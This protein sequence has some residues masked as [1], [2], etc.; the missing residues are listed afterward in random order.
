MS[1]SSL[2]FQEVR[3]S[4]NSE[5]GIKVVEYR[6]NKDEESRAPDKNRR[7]DFRT[8]RGKKEKAMIDWNT[9]QKK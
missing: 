8:P 9:I 6:D 4:R 5:S 2:I 7:G 3:P 1:Q